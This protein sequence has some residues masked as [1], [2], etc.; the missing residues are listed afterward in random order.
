MP[1]HAMNVKLS[2]FRKPL[3]SYTNLA[4]KRWYELEEEVFPASR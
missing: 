2:V 3:T 1:I 4:D